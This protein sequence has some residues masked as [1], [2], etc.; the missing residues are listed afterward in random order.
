MDP[1]LLKYKIKSKYYDVRNYVWRNR[2]KIVF[3]VC[4]GAYVAI[5]TKNGNAFSNFLKSKDIDPLEF[6][7]TPEDYASLKK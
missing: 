6:W 4:L 3:S 5:T 7:L 1:V 2:G